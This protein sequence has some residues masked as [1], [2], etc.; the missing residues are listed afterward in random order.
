MSETATPE[1]EA[2]RYPQIV[3]AIRETPWAILPGTLATILDVVGMRLAGEKFSEEEISARVGTRASSR[4]VDTVGSVAVIPIY[5][6]I[7]PKATLFSEMSGGTSIA[8]LQS[9]FRDALANE[10]AKAI[11]FDID[12]PGGM[13]DGVPELA[14][15][16][17]SARGAKPIVAVANF[18]AASAAYWLAS[19]ADE[20]VASPSADVGSIGVFAAHDDI[21]A[22][23]EKLGVKTTLVSAGPFKTEGN[24]FEPLTEE[25]LA[26]IQDRV[27]EMYDVFTSD[28]AKG[29]ATTQAAV[30]AGYGQ[31]RMLSAARALAEG[32]VDRVGTLEDTVR[33]LQNPSGRSRVAT[34]SAEGHGIEEN[35]IEVPADGTVVTN[36]ASGA[37]DVVFTGNTTNGRRF[38]DGVEDAL[39]ALETVVSRAEEL[40]SLTGTK[41]E[42]LM[43]LIE[44]AEK[45]VA[46]TDEAAQ[47]PQSDGLELE[48]AWQ[49]APRP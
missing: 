27:D 43:A 37:V 3:R 28:V 30:K 20:V 48:L 18:R 17:R 34:R 42:Q 11:V 9:A 19:Q 16:I 33:R 26:A 4:P 2:E 29:M 35:G 40:R 14:A 41:R 7:I 38:S 21:S 5:G 47:D 1:R 10:D 32:M 8:G 22:M 6:A 31:G 13:T 46:K 45:L 12:S 44:R 25:A 15:E 49:L 39:R 36:G 23:Q 24:P